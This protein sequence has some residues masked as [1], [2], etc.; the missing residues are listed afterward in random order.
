MNLQDIDLFELLPGFMK[1]DA[2]NKLMAQGVNNLFQRLSREGERAVIYG[3][4]DELSEAELDQLAQDM[5][6]FWYLPIATIEAKRQLIKDAPLVFSRLGTV[7]AVERVM[8]QYLTN[9]ELQEW[10]EYDGDPHYF[11]F[12]TNDTAILK[13]N[14][15]LFLSILEKIKRKSQWLELIILELQAKGNAYPWVGFIETS[16][17][18]IEFIYSPYLLKKNIHKVLTKAEMAALTKNKY[19]DCKAGAE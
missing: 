2:F 6:I 9:M 15:L 16:T 1:K 5:G 10:F 14:I 13:S 8:N 12:K 4:V 7:W 19:C 17:D 3:H 18:T 11:R